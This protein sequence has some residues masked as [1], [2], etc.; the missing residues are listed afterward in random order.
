M[1]RIK[2]GSNHEV[3]N[4]FYITSMWNASAAA[5]TATATNE[6]ARKGHPKQA[7]LYRRCNATCGATNVVPSCTRSLG[8]RVL[9]VG[10]MT[11]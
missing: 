4:L 1:T 9:G 10:N 11:D 5:A 8:K 6:V 7:I 3:K 2:R